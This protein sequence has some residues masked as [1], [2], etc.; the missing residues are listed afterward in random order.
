[1]AAVD[2]VDGDSPDSVLDQDLPLIGTSFRDSVA[3]LGEVRDTINEISQNPAGSLQRLEAQVELAVAQGLGVDMSSIPPFPN[4]NDPAFVNAGPDG[5]PGTGDDFFDDALFQQGLD[6]FYAAVEAF[7]TGAN[8]YVAIGYEQGNSPGAVTI[9]LKLG[10]CSEIDADHPGCTKAIPL[11]KAFNFSLDDIGADLAGL[12]AAETAGDVSLDYNA[13]VQLDLGVQLPDVA[14]GDLAGPRPFIVDTSFIDLSLAGQVNA[15]FDA[16]IGPFEV[17]VGNLDPLAEVSRIRR[18]APTTPTTTATASVNDGCATVGAGAARPATSASTPRT[19][20]PP[21][22]TL[23]TEPMTTPTTV[24]GQRRLPGGRR[25]R[26]RPKQAP[27]SI[28][29]PTSAATRRP[30]ACTC[31]KAP[32]SPTTSTGSSPRIPTALTTNDAVDCGDRSRGFACA[33]LPI[34]VNAGGNDIYLGTIDGAITGISTRSRTRFDP[35]DITAIK[36]ALIANADNLAW[37]LIGQGLKEFGAYVEEATKGASYDIDIPVVGDALD[38]GA[39]SARRSTMASPSRSVT[40]L[41]PTQP[42]DLDATSTASPGLCNSSSST[43][44]DR[45]AC[46]S[47]ATP[48]VAS[49]STMSRSASSAAMTATSVSP[50]ERPLTT[51]MIDVTRRR[52]SSSRSATRSPRRRGDP[53]RLRVPR[54]AHCDG[55]RRTTATIPTGSRPTVDWSIDVGFGLSL[56]GRLL[57]RHRRARSRRSSSA[58]T[59][60]TRR[61]S[62]PTSPS[63]GIEIDSDNSDTAKPDGRAE[64]RALA[65]LAIN[66][67]DDGDGKL[68]LTDLANVD[69]MEFLPVLEANVDLYWRLET[70]PDFGGASG[71]NGALPTLKGTSTRHRPR[72]RSSIDDGFDSRAWRSG[73]TTSPR[74]RHVH[75][76]VPR[77]GARARCRSSP[78]RCSRSSTSCR[79]RFPASASW[80]SWSAPTR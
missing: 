48:Q 57:P 10:V 37:Q 24:G 19:T 79:R 68:G 45:A 5:T 69:P 34:F 4:P 17:K 13:A 16:T 35:N 41:R 72:R 36:D 67:P 32:T 71:D 49:T 66:L 18:N 39:E 74:P 47:M 28:S 54:P 15:A 58:A 40:F 80:P 76:R 2:N 51:R 50:M 21:T 25:P 70:A 33:S 9:S 26:S 52:V 55:R 62:P 65:D 22:T 20:T 61:T 73:S 78:S 29:R 3:F 11:S 59:T 63:S 1:M 53:V 6:D 38:A 14:N 12:I 42:T 30:P 7:F 31:S 23:T 43:S 44:P 64:R 27:R 77:P 60:S 8:D 75:R 56:R 46:C